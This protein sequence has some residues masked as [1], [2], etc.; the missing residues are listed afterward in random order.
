M[1]EICW[2]RS[3]GL[4]REALIKSDSLATDKERFGQKSL[5][6]VMDN[7]YYN[8]YDQLNSLMNT[9]DSIYIA[10]Q[11]EDMAILDAELNNA[12]LRLEAERLKSQQEMSIMFGFLMLFALVTVAIQFS[13][14]SLNKS[15][16]DLRERNRRELEARNAY[17][18]AME[19]KEIENEMKI[20]VLQNRQ[21]IDLI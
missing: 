15:L 5:L 21:N 1:I 10:V 17:R 9:K 19:S 20:K 7:D 13:Q 8:A 6:F 4:L 12:R 2:L 3:Q 11:N 14:W 16:D 18:K